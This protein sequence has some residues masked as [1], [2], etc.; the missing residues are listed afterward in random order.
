MAKK[1]CKENS[2]FGY[3]PVT[4]QGIVR[5]LYNL[6]QFF[7][8]NKEP[9]ILNQYEQDLKLCELHKEL[10]EDNYFFEAMKIRGNRSLI[11]KTLDELKLSFKDTNI[12]QLKLEDENKAKSLIEIYEK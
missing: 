9:K 12:T 1:Y 7:F 3:I 8:E 6:P 5:E 2:N 4:L 10:E 11:L